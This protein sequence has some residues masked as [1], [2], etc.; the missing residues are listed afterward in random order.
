MK[1]DRDSLF[2]WLLER[3]QSLWAFLKDLGAVLILCRFSVLMLL[4]GLAFLL[5]TPQGQDVLRDLAEWQQEQLRA[6]IKLGLFF[7]ALVL[8]A[9]NSWYWARIMLRFPFADSVADDWRRDARRRFLRKQ[10]PRIIGAAAFVAVAT[11]FFK[12]SSGYIQA[13]N[14]AVIQTHHILGYTCLAMAIVFYLL[15]ALRRKVSSAVHSKMITSKLA[16]GGWFRLLAGIFVVDSGEKDF[17]ADLHSVRNLDPQ[18]VLALVGSL[19]VS[20]LLFLLFLI[21]PVS[22]AVFGTATIVLLAAAS[23]IPFGSTLVHLSRLA[24]FP[25]ISAGLLAAI[26]FSL[27]NDN[28]AIRTLPAV[29]PGKEIIRP[30]IADHFSSWLQSRL[31]TSETKD[32]YPVFV[33]AAEGGGIRAAYWAGSVLAALQDQNPEFA[34]HVYAISGVSGGSL[35]GAVFNALVQE[36]RQGS[37]L[38]CANG[39]QDGN[40][41]PVQGCA[42][43]VLSADFLAPTVAYMLYPDL[44]QRFLPFPLA[45]FDRARALETAWEKGWEKQF[46]NQRFK[47]SFHDLWSGDGEQPPALFL[48]S[49]WVETGKRVILSNLKIDEENFTDSIDFFAITPA[50]LRLSSAVHN[51]ARFTYISPAG[52]VRSPAGKEWGHLVDGGYFENS[53]AATAFEILA[54]MK[55]SAA[56]LE[57]KLKKPIWSR[58]IPVVIMISNDPK[59]EDRSEPVPRQFLN[60]ALS[61]VVT[62][63][64]TRNARA[65]YSRAALRSL[66]ERQGSYDGLYLSFAL[67]DGQGPLPL[68]WVLSELAKETMQK[69]LRGQLDRLQDP[70]RINDLQRFAVEGTAD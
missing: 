69:Q 39:L 46:N 7:V 41:G 37:E 27:W 67:H 23:W 33:V 31:E 2:G 59:L 38:Q 11:A 42:H 20:V 52:T 30:A 68:G 24:R 29:A 22:A 55:N 60:E 57:K 64:N 10:V 40:A 15:T 45:S 43:A 16:E 54:A 14:M 26:I 18:S 61:P 19:L 9:V 66:V 5:W 35:G 13:G 36:Q 70:L 47:Q 6:V 4:A 50:E 8:W 65:S 51:S 58:I 56:T 49:T 12:T 63:L 62:L 34:R 25:V 44:V 17:S 48:N 21:W 1:S 53:G 28:H 3:L 32:R